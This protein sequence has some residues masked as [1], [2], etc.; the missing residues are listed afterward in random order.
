MVFGADY[1]EQENEMEIA[2]LS[3]EVTLLT[4]GKIALE[5]KVKELRKEIERLNTILDQKPLDVVRDNQTLRKRVSELEVENCSMEAA[6]TQYAKDTG[7]RLASL[8]SAGNAMQ[9]Y[10]DMTLQTPHGRIVVDK[11]INAWDKVVKGEE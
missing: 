5:G 8:I 2:R 11:I 9:A 4:G 1:P 3:K 6:S 10:I 7:K